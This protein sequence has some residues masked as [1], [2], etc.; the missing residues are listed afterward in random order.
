MQ[1]LVPRAVAANFLGKAPTWYKQAIVAFLIINPILF[2]FNPFIA[3]WGLV[4]EFIFTL[5]MA[6]K[7]YPLQLGGLLLMQAMYIDMTPQNI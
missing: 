2:V 7:C 6:I 4:I 3:G 5:A 1:M